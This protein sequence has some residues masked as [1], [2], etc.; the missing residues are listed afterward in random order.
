MIK[1][2]G[3]RLSFLV[4]FAG[5]KLISYKVQIKKI[6]EEISQYDSLTRFK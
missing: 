6:Y 2:G 4:E 1:R 3:A 5:V